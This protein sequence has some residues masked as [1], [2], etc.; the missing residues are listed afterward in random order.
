MALSV[1]I[2]Q[3]CTLKKTQA[4]KS[5]KVKQEIKPMQDYDIII[6]GG[7][8]TGLSVALSLANTHWNIC[9]LE[10]SE[11]PPVFDEKNY[12]HRVSALN[13]TSINLLKQLGAWETMTTL[14]TSPYFAMEVWDGEGIGKIEF[15][16]NEAGLDNLGYIIE[17]D[18]TVLG[19]LSQLE[20]HS[21]IELKTGV[22]LEQIQV[23]KGGKRH[24]TL[25]N[26]EELSAT[27]LVGCDGA[28][29]FV[30]E[31]SNI[32]MLTWDYGHT[33]IVASLE[34]EKPHSH[35]ARQKFSS[36]SI[37]AF[38]PLAQENLSS[39]V[40]SMPHAKAQEVLQMQDADFCQFVENS[41]EHK[42]GKIQNTSARY[43]FAFTQRTVKQYVE[44]GM[45]LVGD[46]A[47]TIHPLAGQGVNQG[48]LDVIVLADVL[49][50]AAEKGE[51]IG[52]IRVLK[53]YEHRRKPDNLLMMAS[54]ETFK[55]V[56][57]NDSLLLKWA[58][59]KALDFTNSKTMLKNLVVGQ[60]A[61]EERIS[62]KFL[63]KLGEFL[64]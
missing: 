30:R 55:R 47:H 19:L 38:L 45:A 33:G 37:L 15:D 48:F 21:N 56:F 1:Q 61:G 59:N 51:N 34:S 35:I 58:R 54:M 41:F 12:A 46:A 16:A 57:N 62:N 27:L 49:L 13:A 32:D 63:N 18:V 60:A 5:K 31:N 25:N 22:W 7:G 8:M 9:I 50:K 17:N 10:K 64:S 23:S 29:S 28:N 6:A 53:S 52:D 11:K 24:L 20:K 4:T 36:N 43:A 26:G 14:R 39:I 44:T 2:R 3:I 40:F 42:L